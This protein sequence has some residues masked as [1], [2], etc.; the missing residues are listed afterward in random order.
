MARWTLLD[1]LDLST[2]DFFDGD[3]P[4]SPDDFLDSLDD[5]LQV[6]EVV[7]DLLHILSYYNPLSDHWDEDGLLD[8]LFNEV[9]WFEGSDGDDTLAGHAGNDV[10]HGNDGI[11]TAV[12]DGMRGRYALSRDA[13]GV[14]VQDGQ[15]AGDGRDTLQ[16]IERLRFD[17][18]SLALDLEGHAGSVARLIGTLFGPARV[19]DAALVGIGL[20]LKDS[21]M[22]DAALARIAVDSGLFAAA[23]GSHS[24][25]D[26][27]RLVYRN[28]VGSEPSAADLASYVSLLDS[29]AYSQ[30]QLATIACRVDINAASVELAGLADTG[31]AYLPY[32]G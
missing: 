19:H 13:D 7:W 8:Y 30:A 3:R 26:F 9:D 27:V 14:L 17:D 23:A 6:L 21:G 22:S 10:L 24:N 20:Q 32:G 31:L 11:D 18:R 29:G 12:Y 1:P 28:V 4:D 2:L 5:A 15:A 16:G 25:A